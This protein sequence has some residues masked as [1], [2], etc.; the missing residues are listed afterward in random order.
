[1]QAIESEDGKQALL[2]LLRAPSGEVRSLALRVAGLLRLSESPLMS[3]VFAGAAKESLDE[4]QPLETRQA[5]IGMLASAPY[6]MLAETVAALLDPRQPLEVQVAAIQSLSS[7]DDPAVA[8]VLLSKW[9]AFTPSAQTAVID[10]IFSRVNR[11]PGLLD[12]IQRGDVSPQSLGT[13]RRVHLLEHSD[14]KVRNRAVTLLVNQIPQKSRELIERYRVALSRTRDATRGEAVFKK[15]C[16]KCHRLN[17]QGSQVGPDLSAAQN[18]A[19]ESFLLD[20]LQPSAKIT[21][22]YRTYVV[23]D[24]SGRVFTGVLTSET[25]TSVTLRRAADQAVAQDDGPVVEM[26]ILRKDIELMKASDHSLMPDDLEK[27]VSPQNVA[28]LIAYLR[29]TLGPASPAAFTLFEDDPAF[30]AA[31]NQGS[32]TA[33]LDTRD[34]F[35][36]AAALRVTPPQRYSPR[37]SGWEYRIREQPAAGEFRYIRLAWKTRGS[38]AM[39]ELADNG[40]WPPADSTLRRY[41]SGENTTNWK[42]TKVSDRAPTQW[43]VV[44]RDL[45]KDFGDFTLTGIAPT[46][47]G[48]E[49]LFDRIELLRWP[50]R[51][52]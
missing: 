14:P 17:G 46:A 10:A 13:L 22:G 7:A 34:K 5:A 42:A 27:E 31:L 51:G 4:N 23:A 16:A 9:S 12:A 8:E 28:D 20:M 33:T 19:D 40:D 36:G 45:W 18:R 49:T 52:E 26:T 39:I 50:D 48:G 2:R 21:A 24:V 37:I 11:L 1:V 6:E 44:T 47:M 30:I 43:S 15:V 29:K 25:A 35:S 38:G 32:G 3:A 41:Y